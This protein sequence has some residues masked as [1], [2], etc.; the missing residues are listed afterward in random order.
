MVL[1][2]LKGV[3]VPD[4]VVAV[5]VMGSQVARSAA[6]TVR[7]LVAF[8]EASVVVTLV[9]SEGFE[10][11]NVTVAPLTGCCC[12]LKT[13]A[14]RFTTWSPP[15]WMDVRSTC[16]EIDA[17]ESR[18][19]RVA[20]LG[21]LEPTMAVTVAVPAWDPAVSVVVAIPL[22]SVVSGLAGLRVPRSEERRVG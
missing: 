9:L 21:S 10:E 17:A 20:V 5:T 8:P 11:E 1:V 3:A 18:M 19:V 13:N 12:A 6:L 22:A 16:S 7:V 4:G 2:E 14:V 15:L